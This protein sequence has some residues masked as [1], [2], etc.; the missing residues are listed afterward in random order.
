MLSTSQLV[1]ETG[2]R[3]SIRE[4]YRQAIGLIIRDAYSTCQHLDIKIEEVRVLCRLRVHCLVIQ[5]YAFLC[6]NEVFVEK[7]L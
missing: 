3:P 4:V 5:L 2:T 7:Y 1:F 6:I